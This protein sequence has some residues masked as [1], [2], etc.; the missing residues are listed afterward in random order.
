MSL[1]NSLMQPLR[2][3]YQGQLDRNESRPSRYSAFDFF[4]EEN[5]RSNSI[6]DG[7][8]RAKIKG[9]FNNSVQIPVLNANNV[10]IGNIRSCVIGDSENTS[11]LVVLTFVTY[12][13]SFTM[14]PSQY[15][16][17]DVGYERD[18][19]RKLNDRLIKFA[20]I[21][22]TACVNALEVA[23]NQFWTNIAAYYPNVGNAL[24]VTQAQKNDFYNNGQA[25]MDEMDFPNP[26]HIVGSTSN[27]PLV[28]RLDNQGSNNGI[29]ENFQLQP[30]TWHLTNRVANAVNVQSTGYLVQEGT[31]ALES[32]IDFD[33]MMG[34]SI[35]D[36]MKWERVMVPIPGSKYSVEMGAFY[37]EDCGDGS[38]LQVPNTGVAGNTRTKKESFEWSV[39]MVFATAFNSDLVNRYNPIV[40]YQIATT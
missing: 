14:Y 13:F 36:Q 17:N 19:T 1:V 33:A 28:R 18:F 9:S 23:K 25:I 15:P 27:S 26:V 2:A 11:Q 34:N 22:D 20:G 21:L 31:C 37:R 12:V 29:N 6:F 39:D 35:G 8:I 40:K 38:N 10:S 7:D 5:S 3:E 32:R 4:N 24:Q 16:N 30:Y